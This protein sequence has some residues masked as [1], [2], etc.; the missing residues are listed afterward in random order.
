MTVTRTYCPVCKAS[1]TETD[2]ECGECTQCGAVIVKGRDDN[3]A[4]T[5]INQS[6]NL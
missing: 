5:T 4:Q 6:G 2:Y 1:L 3:E